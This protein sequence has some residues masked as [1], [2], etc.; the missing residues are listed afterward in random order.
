[1]QIVCL[2]SLSHKFPPNTCQKYQYKL[3]SFLKILNQNI[4]CSVKD[5]SM[6]PI[7][8]ADTILELVKSVDTCVQYIWRIKQEDDDDVLKPF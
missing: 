2:S 5:N 8:E 7:Q 6:F 4:S 3:Q 1:M